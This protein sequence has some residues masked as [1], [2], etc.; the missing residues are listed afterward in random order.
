M[1]EENG[2]F[3][4][5]LKKGSEIRFSFLDNGEKFFA[6]VT[7]FHDAHAGS[8]PVVEFRLGPEEDVFREGGGAGGEVEDAVLGVGYGRGLGLGLDLGG[9]FD[10]DGPEGGAGDGDGL[11]DLEG[12]RGGAVLEE[13]GVRGCCCCH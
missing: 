13:S 3:G 12:E 9:A 5:D 11:V 7:H 4:R 6:S 1:E 2:I 8:A 10:G